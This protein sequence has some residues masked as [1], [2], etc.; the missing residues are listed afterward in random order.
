MSTATDTGMMGEYATA[1]DDFVGQDQAKLQLQVAATSAKIR[2]VAMPH[3]LIA[4]GTPGIGKTALAMLAAKQMGTEVKFVSG[5]IKALDAR[6]LFSSMSDG[7]IL[8]LEEAHTLVAGGKKDAEWLL[9]YLED[10]VILGPRG[11][12]PQPRVTIIATTTDAGRLPEALLS[13]LR[14]IKLVPYTDEQAVQVVAKLAER[15]LHKSLP[16]PPL[17]DCAKIARAAS[18]NP[19]LIRK[20]L[21]QLCDVTLSC[22]GAN[23]TTD[24]H[25][26]LT[27]T[28]SYMGLSEDG[29]TELARTYLTVMLDDFAGQ[30]VGQS[31][32]ADKLQEPGGLH[33]T[34]RLLMDKGLLFKSKAGRLLSSDGI[35][36]ARTLI[37]DS[38][39]EVS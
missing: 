29:L 36:R 16:L 9:N 22:G 4:D 14:P 31:A 12:E 18:N 37:K 3:M 26:D 7:D 24:G 13:R 27:D 2:G 17:Q 32:I 11:A 6:L 5:K 15:A 38:Q 30:P 10:G 20:I 28:L 35:R 1:W 23:I 39:Q 33:M 8:V 25:Y 19:R 34:E 21:E